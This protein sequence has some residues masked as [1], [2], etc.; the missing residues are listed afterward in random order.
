MKIRL[1][2]DTNCLVSAML[3]PDSLVADSFRKAL[4]QGVIITSTE[5][6]QKLIE[7]LHRP[8]F[9]KY[10][11]DSD[12]SFIQEILLKELKFQIIESKI[13]ACSDSKDDKFLSL[14][15]DGKADFLVTG[16]KDLF[17]MER[18]EGTEIITP[19]NF[20]EILTDPKQH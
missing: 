20:I 8:K 13:D 19:R 18:F 6:Y 16:D 10:F 2:F 11:S 17:E 3:S 7:V 15:K 14:A 4:N 12:L 5:C 1:V 9:K